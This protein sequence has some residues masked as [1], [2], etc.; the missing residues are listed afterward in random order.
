MHGLRQAA[1]LGK[2]HADERLEALRWL[3]D[4]GLRI[5]T[6]GRTSLF[7][8]RD[9]ES[10]TRFVDALATV[11]FWPCLDEQGKNEGQW[12]AEDRP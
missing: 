11:G 7:M 3:D 4:E 5:L 2:S 10:V 6:D 12:T 9:G 1:A 8:E